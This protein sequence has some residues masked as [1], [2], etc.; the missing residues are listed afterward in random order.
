MA[1]ENIKRNSTTEMVI[2][3]IKKEIKN[4]DLQP[5]QKI[6]SERK[7]VELLGV[8]RTSVR[9]AIQALSFSGYLDVQ[10]GKGA[11][12]R[13]NAEKYDEISKLISEISDYSLPY[14]MEVRKMMEREFARLAAI[15]ATEEEIEEILHLFDEIKNSTDIHDFVRLDFNFHLYIAKAT[16]NPLMNTLMKIFGEMLH[17]ETHKIVEH[18]KNT[19]SRSIE[20]TQKLVDSIK[21]RNSARASEMMEKHRQIIEDSIKEE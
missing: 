9:E 16:H 11:F 18:S 21:N 14:L 13:E 19:K 10:Q 4:G 5:G 20:T 3:Q 15:R 12:V 7:L 8:S 2:E 17:K 6:P 1:F